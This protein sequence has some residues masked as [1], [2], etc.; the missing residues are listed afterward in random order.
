MGILA[1]VLIA[2]ILAALFFL[3]LAIYS[4]LVLIIAP[5]VAALATAVV[6]ALVAL[7]AGYLLQNRVLVMKHQVKQRLD[8]TMSSVS[9]AGS[10]ATMLAG[11]LPNLALGL[12]ARRPIIG[13]GIGAIA[14]LLASKARNKA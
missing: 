1:V 3:G 8:H 7:L 11:L 2:A 4:S 9:P 14:L 12:L 6:F 5:P 13:L 10:A